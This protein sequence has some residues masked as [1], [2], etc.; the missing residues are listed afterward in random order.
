MRGAHV[1]KLEH[2]ALMVRWHT[3]RTGERWHFTPEQREA[4]RQLIR[5]GLLAPDRTLIA[6]AV[7]AAWRQQ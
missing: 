2:D 5:R 4:R 3:V 1:S 6:E 7:S